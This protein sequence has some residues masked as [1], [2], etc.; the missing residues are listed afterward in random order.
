MV[1]PLFGAKLIGPPRRLRDEMD[2]LAIAGLAG[3]ILV[4]EA[5]VP[6][7][8]SY[9]ADS[10]RF[11]TR[12]GVGS[13]TWEAPAIWENSLEARTQLYGVATRERFTALRAD[14]APG[15]WQPL[16]RQ[17]WLATAQLP[18]AEVWSAE[19]FDDWLE[20]LPRTAPAQLLVRLREARTDVWEEAERVFLMPDAWPLNGQ[21]GG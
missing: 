3:L 12:R 19:H 16:P 2:L 6:G 4:K 15:P 9:Q 8:S 13:L 7:L 10:A 1:G 18:H 5:G 20:Q 11:E 17:A 21:A 14:S